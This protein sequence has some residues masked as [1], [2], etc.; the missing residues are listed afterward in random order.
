M[1]ACGH[2]A[3]SA[4]LVTQDDD[5]GE[6]RT[7]CTHRAAARAIGIDV[8]RAS[9]WGKPVGCQALCCC[10]IIEGLSVSVGIGRSLEISGTIEVVDAHAIDQS[11]SGKWL[12]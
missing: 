1:R 10:R 9:L 11:L 6:V 4:S 7:L 5:E 8:I 2:N 3:E 12:Q